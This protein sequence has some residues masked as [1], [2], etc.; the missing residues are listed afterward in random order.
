MVASARGIAAS[1]RATIATTTIHERIV[2]LGT[3]IARS[4][5]NDSWTTAVFPAIVPCRILR[6]NSR[7]PVPASRVL[8]C[9]TVRANYNS[10][11]PL[12][13]AKGSAFSTGE[14]GTIKT[15]SRPLDPP[16]VRL[17]G[18]SDVSRD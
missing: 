13:A 1:P 18:S 3:L 4:G 16:P 15:L 8:S 2:I 9:P 11:L 5:N 17:L 10:P 6:A 12:F 14:S 7:S